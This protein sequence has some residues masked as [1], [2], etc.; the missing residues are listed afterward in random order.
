MVQE[1]NLYWKLFKSTFIISAFTVGGGF[2][3]I[4][5]MRAKFVEEY[6]WIDDKAALD[7]VAL[8][9]AAPGVVAI[10][11]SIILGYRLGGM[12][13]LA[14]A[15]FA[16]VLPP[17]IM[18]TAI[19][20]FYELFIQNLYIRWLLKGMQIAATAVIIDVAIT[21][22]KSLIKK[23]YYIQLLIAGVAFVTSY[24]F[25]VNIMYIVVLCAIVGF[26]FL[27]GKDYK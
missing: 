9:Q 7:M 11:M 24:F 25:K 1:K 18:L 8:A 23:R 20:Y 2:V 22:L 3:I 16:T 12:R 5:L 21:L 14:T 26:L 13:G 10:N 27:R 6:K 17:L 19:A 4:P 15:T